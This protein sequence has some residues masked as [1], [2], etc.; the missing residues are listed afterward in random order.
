[1]AD[2]KPPLVAGKTGARRFPWMTA[3]DVAVLNALGEAAADSFEALI[4]SQARS[5]ARERANGYLE[6]QLQDLGIGATEGL[7]PLEAAAGFLEAK[8]IYGTGG[9]HRRRQQEFDF[10]D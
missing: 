1:M 3:E 5:V 4:H 7:A 6:C 9:G 8:C 2:L 10:D